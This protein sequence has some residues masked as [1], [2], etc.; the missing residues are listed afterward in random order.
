[1]GIYKRKQERKKKEITL[2]DQE[3]KR[4]N[5]NDKKK[6]KKTRQES[7]IRIKKKE[8]LPTLCHDIS[9]NR[10]TIVYSLMSYAKNVLFLCKIDLLCNYF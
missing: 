8:G 3:K 1:M 10:K 4:K 7:K 6:R 9:R 5:D 2:F